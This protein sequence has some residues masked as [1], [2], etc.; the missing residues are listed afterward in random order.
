MGFNTS[1]VKFVFVLIL[2]FNVIHG[3]S[4]NDNDA[5]RSLNVPL[6]SQLDAPLKATLDITELNKQ[7]ANLID[8]KVSEGVRK[9]MEDLV[10]SKIE[11]EF[12]LAKNK[13]LNWNN[14]SMDNIQNNIKGKKEVVYEK[15]GR[16]ISPSNGKDNWHSYTPTTGEFT[17]N[18]G[19]TQ[20]TGLSLIHVGHKMI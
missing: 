2:K 13:L 4:Q 6:V 12:N 10:D 18:F 11:S 19:Q 3:K 8:A 1:R 9:A 15:C 14:N 17:Q 20:W 7:L 5:L 16:E